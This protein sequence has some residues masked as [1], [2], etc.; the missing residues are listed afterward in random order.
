MR[1]DWYASGTADLDKFPRW[2]SWDDNKWMPYK[3]DV[4]QA[5][6]AKLAHATFE[7]EDFFE[8]AMDVDGWEY[9]LKV[10]ETI[11]AA[12]GP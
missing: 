8:L 6:R 9:E 10:F 3:E 4:Q 5:A 2:E 11:C 12:S 7:E 1:K